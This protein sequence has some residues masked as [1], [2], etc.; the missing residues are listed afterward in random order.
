MNNILKIIISLLVIVLLYISCEPIEEQ[1]DYK[2]KYIGVYD[3]TVFRKT[4]SFY[5]THSTD[6][7][8]MYHQG[9][10]TFYETADEIDNFFP[11]NTPVLNRDSAITLYFLPNIHITTSIFQT[12]L[13]ISKYYPTASSQNGNFSA[14]GDNVTFV[15]DFYPSRMFH[16]TYTVVGKRKK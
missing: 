15:V 1:I 14:N 13:F 4:E 10:I 16:D 11:S 2:K 7:I 3:F 9:E 6:T 5:P 12:G 8:T